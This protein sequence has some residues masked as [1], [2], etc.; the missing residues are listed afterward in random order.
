MRR[1]AFTPFDETM[2][3]GETVEWLSRLAPSRV[4]VLDEI[5]LLRRV[6]GD[7]TTLQDPSWQAS[8]LE[9]ARRAIA[10]SRETPA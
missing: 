1:A 7:N 6:H 9:A 10:R 3:G 4:R 8:Y 5:V 2:R